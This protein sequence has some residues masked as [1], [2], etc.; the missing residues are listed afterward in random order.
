MKN[1]SITWGM[2]AAIVISMSVCGR[3]MHAATDV[4]RARAAAKLVDETLD[5]EAR[6][7]IDD[8]GVSLGPALEQTPTYDPAWWQSGFVYD[9][10]GRE[11]LRWDELAARASKDESLIEYRKTR[12]KYPETVDG[13]VRLAL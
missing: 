6:E 12:E 2:S 1:S 13:Q 10:I 8:R 9:R 7:G 5:R 4:E 3:P 11:W